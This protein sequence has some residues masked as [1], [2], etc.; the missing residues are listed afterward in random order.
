MLDM[1]R[2]LFASHQRVP[3]FPGRVV[4]LWG[5]PTTSG[6]SGVWGSSEPLDLGVTETLRFIEN[7]SGQCDL[8]AVRLCLED[9]VVRNA[10]M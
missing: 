5:G 2:N 7:A 9:A 1:E 10:A 3:S 4:N 6:E 8:V